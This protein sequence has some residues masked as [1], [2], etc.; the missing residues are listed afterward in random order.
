MNPELKNSWLEA[1]RSGNYKQ[2]RLILRG[3]DGYCCL[4]VLCD[5][6]PDVDWIRNT[7]GCAFYPFGVDEGYLGY[8]PDKA[9]SWSGLTD[10][11][12]NILMIM[13]DD[14]KSFEEIA[15]YIEKNL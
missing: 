14:S 15:D 3:R 13:N 5:L 11:Q 4:G 10:E 12:Q 9:S 7:S 6:H 8:L 1:L 2:S